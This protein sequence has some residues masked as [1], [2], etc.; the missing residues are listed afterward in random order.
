MKK[1]IIPLWVSLVFSFVVVILLILFFFFFFRN[2]K[3]PKEI[4]LG[5]SVEMSG[6]AVLSNYLN[7]QVQV[8]G[9]TIPFADLIRLWYHDR[10]QYEKLLESQTIDFF[11]YQAI[12]LTDLSGKHAQ[13]KFWLAIQEQ[14]RATGE[15]PQLLFLSGPGVS[16][17]NPCLAYKNCPDAALTFLPVGQ[18]VIS[19]AVWSVGV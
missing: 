15:A 6:H 18:K 10:A 17:A 13:Q 7:A 8:G 4:A 11:E 1:G 9:E 2:S 14:P 3:A 5:E 19:V 12:T 16:R